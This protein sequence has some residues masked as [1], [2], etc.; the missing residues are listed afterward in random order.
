MSEAKLTYISEEIT[1]P[2]SFPGDL[3]KKALK[4]K[5]IDNI[6][7]NMSKYFDLQRRERKEVR[8]ETSQ[9]N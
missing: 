9:P 3:L 8:G 7:G 6:Q 4:E 1:H 2:H 5:I